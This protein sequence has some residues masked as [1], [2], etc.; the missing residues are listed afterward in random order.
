MKNTK[1]TFRDSVPMRWTMLVLLSGLTFATYWFQDFMGGLKGLMETEYG[2]TSENFGRIIGLTTIANVCGMVIVGGIILDKWGIRLAGLLFG[3]LAAFGGL[4]VYLA[5]TGVFGSETGTR[6]WMMI[7]GRIMFGTG[8]EVVCV[9]ATRTVVKWFKGYELALAMAINVGFGR[10]G[11]AMGIAVSP[12][13]AVMGTTST[14]IGF[15]A[16]LLGLGLIMFVIYMF[17]DVKLDRQES[18]T[19]STSEEDTFRMSDLLKLLKNKPYIYI[20]LLC[21]V[22]YSGVF[23]FIQYAPDLLVHKFGF[24]SKLPEGGEVI[25]AGSSVLGNSLIFI[26][27]FIFAI[28]FSTI[29]SPSNIK[30]CQGRI[31][32]R[33][34]ILLLFLTYLY[35]FKD[36]FSIWLKNG[37]KTAAL[38]PL[39]TIIFTPIFGNVVDNKGKAAS[40][41]MLGSLILIFAHLSLSVFNSVILGYLGLLSMGIAFSLVPAAMWPSVAKIIPENKLGTAYAGMFTVQN[42]GLG[43]FFWGIGAVLEFVN[44]SKL[45]LIKAEKAA[46]DYTIPILLLAGCGII[47]IFLAYKLKQADKQSGYG[48]EEPNVK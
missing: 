47:S 17:F 6:L 10:L 18:V 15:S 1:K 7:V 48:L 16:S 3:G 11:T 8:L 28:C 27:L 25:I 38:I 31:I 5:S 42:W 32:A 4:I 19:K 26:G 30:T 23:P 9:V 13:I 44:Q 33:L 12:D 20:T 22:F 21:V 40:L 34:V 29:P 35:C 41:M 43:I 2:F 24:T 45:E 14:A 39:G 36:V 37:A 46:Y